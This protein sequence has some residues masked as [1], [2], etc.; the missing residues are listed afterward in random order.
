MVN[1]IIAQKTRQTVSPRRVEGK[2]S[3]ITD[4]RSQVN[5]HSLENNGSDKNNLHFSRLGK[6]VLA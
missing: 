1:W 6:S 4:F 2:N 5:E 3:P